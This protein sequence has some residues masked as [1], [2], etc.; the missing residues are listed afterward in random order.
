MDKKCYS[1]KTPKDISQFNINRTKKDGL[2]NQCKECNKKRDALR[3]SSG[4]MREQN[5]RNWA[6]RKLD[7]GYM[8]RERVRKRMVHNKRME[9]D[10]VYRLRD[11]VTALVNATL[12]K[13]GLTKGRAS[14]WRIV[15]YTPLDLSNHLESLFLDGMSWDNRKL[16]HVD[17]IIPQ[18]RFSFTSIYDDEFLRCW[19]LS[20]LQPLWARDNFSKGNMSTAKARELY[21]AN[22]YQNVIETDD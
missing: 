2:Q 11:R 19:S 18:S 8:K 17:H 15:G 16:W 14:F 9:I 7:D 21:G 22:A 5:Q 6:R 10:S 12:R 20:N 3:V 13:R 4:K 1:C